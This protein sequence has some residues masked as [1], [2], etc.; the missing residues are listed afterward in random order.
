MAPAILAGELVYFDKD[1]YDQHT[2][3]VGDVA[4]YSFQD[5]P[6][7]RAKRIV[8]LGPTRL[9]MRDGTLLLDGRVVPE[10]YVAEGSAT[11]DYSRSWGPVELPEGCVYFLGDNRDKSDDSRN[12]GC[13]ARKDLLGIAR[14]V[15]SADGKHV[16]EIR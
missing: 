9:E 8:A 13:A 12:H 1:H 16:R 6:V 11:G 10:P 14:Y 2:P 5:E 3:K 4:L 15:S 7:G